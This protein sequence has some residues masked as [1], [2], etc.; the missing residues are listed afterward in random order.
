MARDGE[1]TKF[2]LDRKIF[3]SDIWYDSPWVLKIW[4]YLLGHAN[5]KSEEWMGIKIRRGQ[6]IRSYRTIAKD[7]AYKIGYR[8]KKP[9]VDTVRRICEEF[10]KAGRIEQRNVQFGTLFTILNY[11]KL[12]PM[13]KRESYNEPDSA[14]YNG[15]TVTVQDKNDNKNDKECSSDSAHRNF[16]EHFCKRYKEKTG[17]DYD[18]SGGK[19]GKHVKDML[20]N[21]PIEKLTLWTDRFFES[22]DPFVKKAGYTIGVFK[23]QLNK[24][25]GLSKPSRGGG[26]I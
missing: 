25:K 10:T 23:S 5:H 4:I 22:S 3:T 19:D 8:L 6:L 7:C 17:E 11:N 9:S 21:N 26:V 13:R 1:G 14:S 16:I 20:L 24:L 2:T 15:R 12:Q 18:F